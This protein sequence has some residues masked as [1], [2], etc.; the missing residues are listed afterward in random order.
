MKLR[1]LLFGVLAG[2]AFVACTND[3]EPAGVTPVK[4]ADEVAAAP[5][6]MTVNFVTSDGAA[7]RA[8]AEEENAIESAAFIFFN[9]DG[10]EQVA[11]PFIIAKDGNDAVKS[12][13]YEGYS[14]KWEDTTKAVVVLE[15]PT[16]IPASLVVLVNADLKV[17]LDL[18]QDADATAIQD[19]LYGKKLSDLKNIAKD[20]SAAVKGKFVMSNAVYND[21]ATP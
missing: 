3:N 18:A 2:V 12:T 19:A 17:V 8:T 21:A 14:K 7:T 20:F 10:S 5:K 9:A 11:K 4:G 16:E 13:K 15:N 1:H 6:Y